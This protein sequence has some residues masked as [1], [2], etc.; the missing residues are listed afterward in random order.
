MFQT[1][2]VRTGWV[3]EYLPHLWALSISIHYLMLIYPLS[4]SHLPLLLHLTLSL[5][6][7]G[8]QQAGQDE[9]RRF[10]R[11]AAGRMFS[12]LMALFA[13]FLHTLT[14]KNTPHKNFLCHNSKSSKNKNKNKTAPVI[15]NL[16]PAG[17]C[18]HTSFYFIMNIVY[19]LISSRRWDI[20]LVGLGFCDSMFCAV[21]CST[22]WHSTSSYPTAS[23][24]HHHHAFL[25]AHFYYLASFPPSHTHAPVYLTIL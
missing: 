25:H 2:R 17:A 12:L 14:K 10:L 3:G 23:T 15:P 6:Q 5:S 22:A 21:S 7:F 24:T 4:V 19:S 16:F 13:H 18:S 20:I 11:D 8:Y 9:Q 1:R